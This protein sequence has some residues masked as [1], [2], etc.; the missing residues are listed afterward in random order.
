MSKKTNSSL[1][2]RQ[3]GIKSVYPLSNSFISVT[4]HLW[5]RLLVKIWHAES[6]QAEMKRSGMRFFRIS[7]SYPPGIFKGY[8][9][10]L[11]K[12]G[13]N[14]HTF[15]TT[16]VGRIQRRKRRHYYP[17]SRQCCF[18]VGKLRFL[19]EGERQKLGK[20]KGESRGLELARG[21]DWKSRIHGRI[22]A[23]MVARTKLWLW[24]TKEY[25]Q[26]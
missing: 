17:R 15:F 11:G 7:S 4:S 1:D 18:Q 8:G 6:S 25:L 24:R 22:C 10:G 5:F 3:L 13:K 21:N 2:G 16:Q 20:L 23:E 19:D 26:T 12:S 14:S 9:K